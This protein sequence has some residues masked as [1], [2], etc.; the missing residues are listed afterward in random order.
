MAFRSGDPGFLHLSAKSFAEPR[1][2]EAVIVSVDGE[3]VKTLVRC[4]QEELGSSELSALEH[5]GAHYCLVEA[6]D[7]QFRLGAQG[8]KMLLEA[9]SKTLVAAAK[10]MLDSTDEEL[11]YATASEPAKEACKT[12]SKAEEEGDRKQRIQ[13]RQQQPSC[14][15]RRPHARTT[16]KELA[17]QWYAKRKQKRKDQE[18]IK[19]ARPALLSVVK[20]EGRQRGRAQLEA[21]CDHLADRSCRQSRRSIA[22]PVGFAARTGR[23]AS[24]EERQEVQ[25]PSEESLNR[26]QSEPIVNHVRLGQQFLRPAGQEGICQSRERLPRL[27]E[28]DV[29]TPNPLHQ[30]VCETSGNGAGGGGTSLQVDGPQPPDTFRQAAELQTLPLPL[31]DCVGPHPKGRVCPGGPPVRLEPSS[32]T[33]SSTRRIVG[34]GLDAESHRG[35]IQGKAVRRRPRQSPVRDL[36]P[37]KHEGTGTQHGSA[38]EEGNRQGGRRRFHQPVPERS[39]QRQQ[40][41]KAAREGEGQADFRCLSRVRACM[42]EG[43]TQ[44]L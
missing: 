15:G 37:E 1:W 32:R 43:R 7:H 26:L 3:W 18:L 21:G 23:Q 38:Q 44:S 10:Q 8:A 31:W 19:E 35:T 12:Q 40:E 17:R 22:G 36:V 33:S 34:C 30:E 16:Q 24:Q 14:D 20:E 41:G 11:F 6:Q 9:D 2:R 13:Q 27:R 39:G 28:E 42:A 5:S 4:T 29:P 25:R